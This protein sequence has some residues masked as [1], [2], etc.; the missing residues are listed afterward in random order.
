M[1]INRFMMKIASAETMMTASTTAKS[2]SKMESIISLPM[3]GKPK[4]VVD[5]DGTVQDGG[6]LVADDGDHR[7]HGVAQSV[8]EDD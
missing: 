2:R 1:S 4:T 3:P 8:N 5:D 7:Q 6:R